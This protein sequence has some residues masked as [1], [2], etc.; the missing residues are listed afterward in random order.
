[1]VSQLK[2]ILH[3]YQKALPIHHQLERLFRRMDDQ[4]HK[5][6]Q[7]Y[8]FHCTGC[9]ENCCFTLFYHHTLLECLYL[10]TGY[11]KLENDVRTAL[12]Q[13]AIEYET[14]Q[15]L[16]ESRK[17]QTLR[18]ICPLNINGLC[19]LYEYRPMI[20]RLHGIP[21]VLRSQKHHIVRGPG[22]KV[23]DQLGHRP[24]AMFFDRT[25]LYA[26]MAELENEARQNFDF[27]NRI[28]MTIAQILMLFN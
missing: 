18:R 17:D 4:Y 5:A 3:H 15:Q 26:T 9:D 10:Y 24:S 16:V 19:I 22:C 2:D 23:F 20:C 11:C 12:Q 8:G 13:S 1:M 14:S 28:K 7:Q 25:P 6:A 21:Y 27:K